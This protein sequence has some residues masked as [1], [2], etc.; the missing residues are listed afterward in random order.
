MKIKNCT[1]SQLARY[2]GQRRPQCNG[3]KGCPLCWEKYNARTDALMREA[4][5]A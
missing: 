1:T 5:A 2:T 4:K 3:G